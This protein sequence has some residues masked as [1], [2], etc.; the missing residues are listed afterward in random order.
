MFNKIINGD[1]YYIYFDDDKWLTMLK[2]G[3]DVGTVK[4]AA[5][6]EYS[7]TEIF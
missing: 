7:K 2:G 5:S 4:Q 3:K 1:E 6:I